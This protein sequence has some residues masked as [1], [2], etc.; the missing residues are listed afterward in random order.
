MEDAFNFYD[1]DVAQGLFLV[2]LTVGMGIATRYNAALV[3]AVFLTNATDLALN[4]LA[5][6][7][8]SSARFLA[9][10]NVHLWGSCCFG[11]A[12]HGV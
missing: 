8:V 12:T 10:V 5:N 6:V 3:L 4:N 7:G 2:A 11:A 9:D 1:S